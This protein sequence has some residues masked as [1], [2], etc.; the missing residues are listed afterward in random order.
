MNF[1]FVN[2]DWSGLVSGKTFKIHFTLPPLDLILLHNSLPHKRAGN[3]QNKGRIFDCFVEDSAALPALVAEAD[4]IIVTTTPYHMWQCPNAEWEKIKSALQRFP[5]ERLIV[6]GLHASVFPEQTLRETGAH[7][8]IRREPE[9]V[10]RE[11][12]EKGDWRETRGV[13]Y[14]DGETYHENNYAPLPVMDELCVDNYAVDISRY[15]YFLLGKRTGVFEAS[16]GCPWKCTFCDQEMYSW[17]YRAKSPERFTEEVAAAVESTGM[18]SAYFYDLEFT[19]RTDRTLA[20]CEGLIARGVHKKLRWA[21]QTRAD[22]ID[23]E[24]LTAMKKAGCVL[25]HFGVE[26]ANPEVLKA[27]N[28]KITL[29]KIRD[30][31]KLAKMHGFQTACFFMFGLPGESPEQFENTLEFAR[32]LNLTY[33]SFHFAVPFPGTPLYQQYLTEKNLS[34][35]SWPATYF[36]S[37]S[38]PEIAAFISRAF[39]RFYLQPKHFEPRQFLFRLENLPQKLRYFR[40]IQ[41]HG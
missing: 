13:S 14:L 26:S 20:I 25:I 21:C 4:W 6:I 36:D 37:W 19:I 16:R 39:K 3:T 17:K 2:L 34:W 29:D 28:K 18:Q 27:T 15:S 24:M 31:V 30:G 5:R 22:M 40:S 35:G 11:F 23:S 8:V 12:L 1:L 7:A 10:F 41:A 32:D 33:A 9:V 38:Q